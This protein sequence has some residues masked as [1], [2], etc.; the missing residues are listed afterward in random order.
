MSDEE[1]LAE[2]SFNSKK[3]LYKSSIDK[4]SYIDGFIAGLK[5]G[6]ARAKKEIEAELLKCYQGYPEVKDERN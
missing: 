1:K 3:L 2:D 6:E 4:Y 5:A